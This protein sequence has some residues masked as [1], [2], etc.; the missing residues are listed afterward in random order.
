MAKP[1][2]QLEQRAGPGEPGEGGRR[3][4]RPSANR[5]RR[6][7]LSVDEI[8]NHPRLIPC[9]RRQAVALVAIH[10]GNPR[11]ASGF[12]TLQR[13]LMAH[14]AL[15][16]YFRNAS[17]ETAEELNTTK[18]IEAIASRGVASRNTAHAFLKELLKY[19]H[20]R[21]G[22]A[23]P[24]RRIRSI[25]AAPITIAMT[26]TWLA[27]HLTTLDGLDDGDRCTALLAWPQGLAATQPL[28]AD[29]LLRSLAIRKP[30][31]AFSLFAWLNEG[32]IL[33]DWLYSGLQEFAP[34]CPRIPSHVTSYAD[35]AERIHLSR[36]HLSRKLRRAE[37]MGNMG[38]LGRRGRSTMWVSAEF[39][40]EYHRQQAIKLEIIDAAFRQALAAR[41]A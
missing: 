19:G 17:A 22:P 16:H 32:N 21:S 24:D 37:E 28:I 12:A 26:T 38:W 11:I 3:R 10:D 4:P 25:V 31:P 23:G 36:S 39:V 7:G 14:A 5:A 33:M 41:G 29:G 30:A 40:D 13:W 8:V 35:L 34:G 9:V 1:S 20:A 27:T 2:P 15:A 6:R 18:F